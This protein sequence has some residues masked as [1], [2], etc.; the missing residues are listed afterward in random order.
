MS[1]Q[2]AVVIC[3]KCYASVKG[4]AEEHRWYYAYEYRVPAMTALE[5]EAKAMNP[6]MEFKN[7]RPEEL[8][9]ACLNACML[10]DFKSPKIIGLI[11]VARR[12]PDKETQ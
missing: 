7:K 10:C 11:E 5:D 9:K 1:L 4:Y 12:D 3:Q 8:V 6:L 2:K